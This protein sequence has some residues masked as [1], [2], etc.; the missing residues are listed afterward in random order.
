M[1][2]H[3]FFPLQ[4]KELLKIIKNFEKQKLEEVDSLLQNG[5]NDTSAVAVLFSKCVEEEMK[6]YE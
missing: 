5:T 4:V 6:I 2:L 3:S 1:H